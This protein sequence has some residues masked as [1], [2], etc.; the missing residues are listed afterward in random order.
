VRLQN[1]KI[2]TIGAE[3]EDIFFITDRQDRPLDPVEQ[4]PCLKQAIH[5]FVDG[6]PD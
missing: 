4:I 1:A 3:A 2:A 6:P 5:H